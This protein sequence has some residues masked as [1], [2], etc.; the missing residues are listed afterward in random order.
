MAWMGEAALS[1]ASPFSLHRRHIQSAVV[2]C[3]I[4]RGKEHG[5]KAACSMAVSGQTSTC[6]KW[7]GQRV[8]SGMPGR[9]WEGV[10][11]FTRNARISKTVCLAL[12]PLHA[13]AASPRSTTTEA[14]CSIRSSWLSST[15]QSSSAY[16]WASTVR[17]HASSHAD[18]IFRRTF[19]RRPPVPLVLPLPPLLSPSAPTAPV[20]AFNP[21][22]TPCQPC[23]A[24]RT[25]RH[26]RSYTP[27]PAHR[28][29]SSPGLYG[30]RTWDST[31][32]H[33]P[34]VLPRYL[35]YS[36][37]PGFVVALVVTRGYHMI[38]S[39]PALPVCGRAPWKSRERGDV[40]GKGCREDG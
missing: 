40:G 7:A 22:A 5:D 36:M 37:L 4:A 39:R 27:L 18:P 10:P 24:A 31:I 33:T 26:A 28:L 8:S 13:L 6:R 19:L 30:Y 32:V 21:G 11:L 29:C 35:V 2:D 20:V 14:P 3:V 25:C 16:S 38:A 23:R 12:L 34:E 17:C 15:S 1:T 9:Q